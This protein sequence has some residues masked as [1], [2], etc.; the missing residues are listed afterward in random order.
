MSIAWQSCHFRPKFSHAKG[1][2]PLSANRRFRD[3]P[4]RISRVRLTSGSLM[5]SGRAQVCTVLK[6]ADIAK[7][8]A[9]LEGVGGRRHER[10]VWRHFLAMLNGFLLP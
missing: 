3:R 1:C 7:I 9:K 5:K 6:T 8:H 10:A 2:V 4:V